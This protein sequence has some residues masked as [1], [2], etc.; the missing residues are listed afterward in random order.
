MT[1]FYPGKSGDFFTNSV[2]GVIADESLA[3]H[4]RLPLGDILD[5]CAEGRF[6]GAF[7]HRRHHRWYIPLP[8]RYHH[9]P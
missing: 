8:V 6:E 7:Y 5:W 1:R 2:T 3:R 4:L 9:A